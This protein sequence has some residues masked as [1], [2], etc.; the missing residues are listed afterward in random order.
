[1]ANLG[2]NILNQL[3]TN[4]ITRVYLIEIFIP[5][6]IDSIAL[7]NA[8][9]NIIYND[10]IFFSA[11]SLG[12][13]GIRESLVLETNEITLNLSG[14]TSEYIG[15]AESVN[16]IGSNAK[17]WMAFLEPATDQVL[18]QPVLLWDGKITNRTINFDF[19]LKSAVISVNVGDYFARFDQPVG[20]RTNPSE[21]K[22]SFPGDT[23]FDQIP[24]IAS[25]EIEF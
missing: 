14:I 12:I 3:S 7:T 4:R 22:Q 15:V 6:V 9:R 13:E 8:A 19:K 18:D 24:F 5:G 11:V 21:W 2:T 17:V 25:K 10:N 16:F 20:L 23:I 1:M